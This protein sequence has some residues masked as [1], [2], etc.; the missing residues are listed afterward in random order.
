MSH[1]NSPQAKEMAHE[2]MVRN[3]AAQVEAIWP[4]EEA[5]F[6]RYQL[7]AS[8]RILDVGCGTGEIIPHLLQLFDGA[9]V[10]GVDLEESHLALARQRTQRW[11]GRA[12]FQTEDAFA[13]SFE[14]QTFDLVVSRHM[15][16]AIP[17]PSRALAEMKRVLKPGGR[18]HALAEDYGMLWCHPTPTDADAFWQV[19]PALYGKAIGCE[20]HVG[21]K[22]FGLLTELGMKD[23]TVDYV[24]VDTL[25]VPREVFARI[26]E[27]WRDGYSETIAR[28]AGVPLEQVE[29]GWK[30]ML[31]CV[32]SPGGYALWQV[33]VW[34]A[35]KSG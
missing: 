22:M 27:A 5:L 26:W 24:V 3:L 14:D 31:D 17:S 16:Q 11:G 12:T 6:R 18:I 7:P 23:I 4:Q 13:L 19:L 21:R 2:S 20:V 33:P 9:T 34:S 1:A 15:L 10:T 29:R 28:H 35:V 8:A 30:E 32:R 25:R